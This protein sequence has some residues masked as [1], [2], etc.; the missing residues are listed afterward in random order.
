M[1]RFGSSRLRIVWACFSLLAAGIVL[2][3]V[4]PAEGGNLLVFG[5]PIPLSSMTILVD[6]VALFRGA[7]TNVITTLVPW[8]LLLTAIFPVAESVRGG[9]LAET[10]KTLGLGLLNGLFYSQVILLPVWAASLRLVGSPLPGPL[11][12]A[13]LN[14][15]LL[16]IQLTLWATA[17]VALIR[18]NPGMAVLATAGLQTLGKYMA[19]GGEYLGDPDVFS[20]PKA[21]VKLMSLLGKLLPT[22]QVPTDP[23]ALTALPLSLGGPILLLVAAQ[24][25]QGKFGGKAKAPRAA[26]APRKAKG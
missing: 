2:G 5:T 17:L 14:A 24:L 21:L 3:G 1:E 12:L 25:L 23:M 18:S 9:S 6:P 15:T 16:G 8:T 13:D 22:G 10:F 4:R 20:V 26:K 11:C 7:L 19:W